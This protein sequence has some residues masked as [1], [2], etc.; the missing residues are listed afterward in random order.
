MQT[1]RTSASL[2]GSPI[3]LYQTTTHQILGMLNKGIVPWRSPI[4][5]TSR[6]GYP[7]NLATGKP[8]RGV[9]VFLLAH[10]AFEKGYE[11]PF[12]LG[13]DQARSYGGNVKR[14][15]KSTQVVFWK[16]TEVDDERTGTTRRRYVL[17]HYNLF[18]VDQTEGL[19]MPVPAPD[20][21]PPIDPVDAAQAIVKAYQAAPKIKH[22]GKDRAPAYDLGEDLIE[23]PMAKRFPSREAYFGTLFQL[24]SR[25]TGHRSR[26]DR[27]F[28]DATEQL[29]SEMS[30]AFLCGE[31]R[32]APPEI[33]NASSYI[34][35]CLGRFKREPRLIINAAGAATRSADWIRG[36]R[37]GK[38]Q[39]IPARAADTDP[40][41]DR[42]GEAPAQ[43]PA[44]HPDA[45]AAEEASTTDDD[46]P[47]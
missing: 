35:S 27:K 30:A 32:I 40:T 21:A 7:K 6:A 42:A 17:S 1:G 18:N 33:E 36:I 10:A 43:E 28:D 37:P 46:I 12:W 34:S 15:E 38:P 23:L 39:P 19:K 13:Y 26:L 22:V 5:G 8:Y 25:S 31:A 47:F 16:P 29:I 4:L 45:P 44:T 11:S 3:D 41:D 2:G 14:G 9:N 24:L 20:A